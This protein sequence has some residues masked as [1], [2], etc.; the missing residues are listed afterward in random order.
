MENTF[1]ALEA[2]LLNAH[3][4]ESPE[5][6]EKTY[7]EIVSILH[8]LMELAGIDTADSPL[9]TFSPLTTQ[10][11]ELS[12][13]AL[14]FQLKLLSFCEQ[15]LDE[16]QIFLTQ[17]MVM[18]IK[19]AK[20]AG[21][22]FLFLDLPT[23]SLC[24]WLDS[25]FE[26]LELRTDLMNNEEDTWLQVDCPASRTNDHIWVNFMVTIQPPTKVDSRNSSSL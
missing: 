26:L 3:K 17:F 16:V 5:D 10:S 13:D 19:L 4:L 1:S 14:I 2:A 7:Q 11:F 18:D 15:H 24:K 6:Q 20:E 25:H 8:Q 21:N 9:K 22:P 12:V 23:E